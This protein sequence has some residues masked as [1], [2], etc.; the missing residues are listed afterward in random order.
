M[1][2]PYTFPTLYNEV[3][4]INITKLKEWGYLHPMQVKSGVISW[5]MN[6]NRTGSISISVNTYSKQPYVELDYKYKDKPI[7]YK[8]Q[9]V[10]TPSNLGK[11]LIWYFLCPQ[12][13]RRCRKLYSIDGYFLHRKAFKG[14]M[15]EC[16][17]RSKNANELIKTF[18]T[19]LRADELQE[20]LN[21]KYFKKYYK[22][23]PTKK[24]LK[25]LKQIQKT[26]NLTTEEIKRVLFIK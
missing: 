11:G 26:E 3:L 9:L 6:E 23:K 2:K 24:Y 18:S 25:I 4:Q 16:Q 8:I 5:S 1:P 21:K 14:C 13:K 10:S 7:K 20:Q 19:I 15:Y 12:T 22:G 17:T